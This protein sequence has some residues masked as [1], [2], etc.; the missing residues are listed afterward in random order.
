[1]RFYIEIGSPPFLRL[2]SWDFQRRLEHIQNWWA[3]RKRILRVQS[4]S[5]PDRHQGC[6]SGDDSIRCKRLWAKACTVSHPWPWEAWH[7]GYTCF[8]KAIAI[9]DY[10]PTIHLKAAMVCGRAPL[11]LQ[12]KILFSLIFNLGFWCSLFW[13]EV[14]L[15]FGFCS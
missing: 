1:M 3:F 15:F 4:S 8:E 11:T 10:L 13:F 6:F 7:A 5:C 2:C 12:Q 9:H 14:L